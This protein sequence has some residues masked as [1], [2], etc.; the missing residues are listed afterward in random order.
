MAGDNDTAAQA[1][2][3]D[4]LMWPIPN[5]A[6]LGW[7]AIWMVFL[8]YP[9]GDILGAGYSPARAVVAWICLVAFAATYLFA[10]WVCLSLVPRVASGVQLL[11]LVALFVLG[12]TLALV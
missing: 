4:H 1:G 7:A 8:G 10:M 9:I 2:I 11:P 3:P 6:R 5:A 12:I